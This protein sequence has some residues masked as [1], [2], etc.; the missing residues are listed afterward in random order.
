MTEELVV[1]KMASLNKALPAHLREFLDRIAAI[2]VEPVWK[3]SLNLKWF[4]WPDEP[5][6]LGYVD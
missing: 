5:V 3:A 4:G 1:E 6:N 2:G